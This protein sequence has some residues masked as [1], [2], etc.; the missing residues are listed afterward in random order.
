MPLGGVVISDAIADTFAERPFPGGLTYSGHPL[1][2]AA[3]VASINAMQDEGI[4]D[5]A[6]RIGA[7][8]LGPGLRDL[9]ERHPVGR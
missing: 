9:A 6:R 2:C 8:V 5:N 3:A 7:E 1:A 4:I